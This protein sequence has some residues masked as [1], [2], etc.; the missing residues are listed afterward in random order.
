MKAALWPGL[1]VDASAI[2]MRG[3]EEQA[4]ESL[5]MTGIAPSPCMDVTKPTIGAELLVVISAMRVQDGDHV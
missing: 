1:M 2:W 3:S 5:V 4:A